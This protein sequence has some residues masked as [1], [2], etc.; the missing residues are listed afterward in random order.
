MDSPETFALVSKRRRFSSV[1]SASIRLTESRS[2]SHAVIRH[3]FSYT[4]SCNCFRSSADCESNSSRLSSTVIIHIAHHHRVTFGET[5][6]VPYLRSPVHFIFPHIFIPFPA[7]E[8]T[9]N[10]AK[11]SATDYDSGAFSCCKHS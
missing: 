7:A 10:S 11:Q 9:A 1:F 4:S 5:V 2:S 3:C 6:R 8:C